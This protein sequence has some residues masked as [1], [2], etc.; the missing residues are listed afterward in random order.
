MK[1]GTTKRMIIMLIVAAVILGGVVG[2]QL[3]KNRMIAKFMHARAS[4]TQTVAT[5]VARKSTWQPKVR[6]LGNMLASEQAS[7]S[8]EVGGLVTAIHFKSG[9]TVRAGQV[10]VELNAVP[11]KA[12]L[13]QLQ[14]QAALAQQN[15][16]RDEAQ[17]RIQAISRSV[18]DNDRAT[19]KSTRAQVK[20]QE[21]L[22]A[23]KSIVAPFAG[24]LGIRQVNLGQYLAPGTAVVTLQKLDPMEV[25]FSVPQNQIEL[26]HVGMP[27]EV[28]TNSVPGKVF[29][30]SVTAIEPQVDLATRNLTVRARVPNPDGLLLPGVFASVRINEGKPQRYITLPNAAVTYNPYGATVFVVKEGSE[31]AAGK[32][33]LEAEQ[34]FVITGP[35]RGDQVAILSGLKEGDTVVTA[36]QMKLRNGSPIVVNNNVQPSN[37]PNPNVP[38]S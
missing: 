16:K 35:T 3:F 36:G 5:I 9:E 22:I 18:V 15:L 19:L 27:A 1:E 24:R 12:Q 4:P 33:K 8:A 2:F 37:S 31:G 11:Q 20:A 14:A 32:P 34:R 29:A 21:A 30:A 23:Q 10:L 26:I 13:A 17:L 6:A 38:D 28:Q 7:L 25:D